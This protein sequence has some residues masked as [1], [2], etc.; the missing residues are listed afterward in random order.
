MGWCKLLQWKTEASAT[1]R[2]KSNTSFLKLASFANHKKVL[3]SLCIEI[4]DL[5]ADKGGGL[6]RLPRL[7]YCRLKPDYSNKPMTSKTSL[8]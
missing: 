2:S 7:C 1:S 8:T 5:D 6:F 3:H 4:N